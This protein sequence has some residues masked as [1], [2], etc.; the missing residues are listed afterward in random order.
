MK[1]AAIALAASV[2]AVD[3]TANVFT[4]EPFHLE[5]STEEPNNAGFWSNYDLVMG[6]MIGFYLP[7][8]NYARNYD[9]FSELMTSGVKMTM[10]S[11][12]FDSE[13]GSDDTSLFLAVF[14]DSV[15]WAL[16]ANTCWQQYETQRRNGWYAHYEHAAVVQ[17]EEGES[18]ALK[19]VMKAAKAFQA[20]TKFDGHYKDSHLYFFQK[21]FY[22]AYMASNVI[23]LGID[24][25]GIDAV[26]A[27]DPWVR[28]YDL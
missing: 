5:A 1:T 9:C 4:H 22:A 28:Y 25:L 15:N 17:A 3:A 27:Q 20:W 23:T 13:L 18:H 8:N 10:Y 14:V 21:G 6:A 7:I 26:Q 11:S 19:R 24:I 16:T 2:L 12:Y